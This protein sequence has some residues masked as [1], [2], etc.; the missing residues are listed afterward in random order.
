[1]SQEFP[2]HPNWNYKNSDVK[3]DLVGVQINNIAN[4]G[5]MVDLPEL[6]LPNRLHT[7]TVDGHK[8]DVNMTF[9]TADQMQEY[10]RLAIAQQ[11]KN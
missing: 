2:T 11:G 7:V 4:A 8:F 3:V 1:M 10:A 6:P 9:Y 5:N